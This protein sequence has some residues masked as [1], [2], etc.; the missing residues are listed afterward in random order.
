MLTL[1][2]LQVVII[3]FGLALEVSH[4]IKKHCERSATASAAASA[5]SDAAAA[6]AA[7]A[8]SAA[9]GGGA[10]GCSSDCSRLDSAGLEKW[11]YGSP[12]YA[13][14]RMLVCEPASRSRS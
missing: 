12:A 1:R 11:F 8:A 9:S 4:E 5:V 6:A 14:R 10:S 2:L 7:S 13:S 3:D